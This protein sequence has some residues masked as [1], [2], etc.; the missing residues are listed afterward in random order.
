MPEQNESPFVSHV[1]VC[2]NDRGGK[3]QSC[4]DSNSQLVKSCLK[5]AVDEKGWKGKVRVSTSGCMGLCDKGANVMIY[6][7]KVWLSK[8]TPDA[9][10]EIISVIEQSVNKD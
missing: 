6:P 9:V 3:R 4:A 7:Q 8:V 10:D 5:D 1:F 2:T